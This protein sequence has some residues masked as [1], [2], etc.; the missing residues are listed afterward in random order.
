MRGRNLI[1]LVICIL[2]LT[3]CVVASAQVLFEDDF[4][5]DLSKWWQNPEQGPYG[6]EDGRLFLGKADG[7]AHGMITIYNADAPENTIFEDFVLTFTLQIDPTNV[8]TWRALAVR[9]LA[10][11]LWTMY[12][13]SVLWIMFGNNGSVSVLS[14]GPVAG[15]LDRMAEQPTDFDFTIPKNVKIAKAG[16]KVTVYVEEELIY[17]IDIVPPMKINIKSADVDKEALCIPPLKESG[18]I[19]FF[20]HAAKTYIDDVKVTTN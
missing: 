13:E 6:I 17:T 9:V 10:K 16:K 5:G 14:P 11:D 18:H 3:V 7:S 19:G 2:I 12:W 20:G 4:S 1:S 8:D 15:A